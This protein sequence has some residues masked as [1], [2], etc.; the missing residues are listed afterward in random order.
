VLSR[1]PAVDPDELRRTQH[2]A[3]PLEAADDLAGE[4]APDRVRLDEHEC[5]LRC[6]GARV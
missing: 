3:A 6:H 5:P 1:E 4:A 2:K